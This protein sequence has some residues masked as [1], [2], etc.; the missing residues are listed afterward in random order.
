[1]MTGKVT[2]DRLVTF[3]LKG[4]DLSKEEYNAFYALLVHEQHFTTF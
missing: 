2:L 3:F 1:M 4:K